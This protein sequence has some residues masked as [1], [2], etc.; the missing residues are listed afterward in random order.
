MP[1]P[2]VALARPST[3]TRQAVCLFNSCPILA[4]SNPP[5]QPPY[6]TRYCDSWVPLFFQMPHPSTVG[7]ST[8]RWPAAQPAAA[9]SLAI[10][11]TAA[12]L[13]P[14]AQC[15]AQPST[16]HQAAPSTHPP[17]PTHL[18]SIPVL[19]GGPVGGRGCETGGICVVAAD[20]VAYARQRARVQ[21]P[22]LPGPA[23]LLHR[24]FYATLPG[25]LPLGPPSALPCAAALVGLPERA[26]L[27]GGRGP[28]REARDVARRAAPALDRVACMQASG[29]QL[30]AMSAASLGSA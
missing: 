3:F 21:L 18:V 15:S 10:A 26:D 16:T 9:T 28:I 30:R 20:E 27:A 11:I 1:T 13:R 19:H 22:A 8:Q 6:H 14:A 29:Q 24:I 12:G 2:R 5:R 4:A 23:H 17:A 25:L 7:A